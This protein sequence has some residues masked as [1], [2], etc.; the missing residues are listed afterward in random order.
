MKS[1][2][3]FRIL[4][5]ISTI[6]VSALVSAYEQAYT[7]ASVDDVEVLVLPK[8]TWIATEIEG[9][10]FQSSDVL[11]RRLFDYIKANEIS[12]TVPVEARL[13]NA[14][15]RFHLPSGKGAVPDTSLIQVREKGVRHVARLG[16]E[17]SYSKD[18]IA[19]VLSRLEAWVATTPEWHADGPAYA[20]FWDGP[21]TPWFMKKFEVHI[22]VQRSEKN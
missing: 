18:N 5:F 3:P 8:S 20:V 22:V 11:F 17:G 1:E 10:Y 7:K 15:M 16:G 2:M 9:G 14:E 4:V 12:M 21:F 19:P 13:E 6:L